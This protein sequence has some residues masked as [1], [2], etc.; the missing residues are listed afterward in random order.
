MNGDTYRTIEAQAEAV[1]T[2]KRSRFIAI[3]VPV[4]S[5][6]DVK[7][8]LESCKRKYHNAHHICYA[9]M[10]G[11]HRD[12]FRMNDNGEPS[13]T[14]GRP[15]LNQINAHSLTNVLLMVVR[16]FGGIKLGTSGLANAYKVAAGEVLSAA[17][18]IEKTIEREVT[19]RFEYL[20]LNEVMRIVKGFDS[21]IIAHHYDSDC[22]IRISI[23]ESAFEPFYRQIK[24][25]RTVRVIEGK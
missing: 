3:A 2:E 25:I 24:D 8:H 7:A 15:I 9:Y 20:Q 17:T 22:Q 5:A 16:Y 1:Y 18:I 10:L 4:T 23:A 21:R 14:A 12:E 11:Q 13:G 19:L 6:D